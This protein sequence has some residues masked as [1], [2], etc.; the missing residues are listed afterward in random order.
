MPSRRYK[1][2]NGGKPIHSFLYQLQSSTSAYVNINSYKRIQMSYERQICS[3]RKV[4]DC[5]IHL[6]C[7]GCSDTHQCIGMSTDGH[8][9]MEFN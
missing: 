8:N 2:F 7:Q 4:Y 5:K 6:D 1:M 9:M 3:A